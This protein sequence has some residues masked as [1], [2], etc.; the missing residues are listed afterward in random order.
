MPSPALLFDLDGTLVDTAPDL[1]G[2][3]NAVL[4][5]EERQTVDPTTLRHMV[6]HGARAL[7]EQAMAATGERAAPERLPQLVDR[8]IAH[9]RAHIV[10]GSRAFPGVEETL[11]QLRRGGA[12]LAV[13]TNK[14]QVLTEPILE[15]LNL[16]QHF[17]V[18]C[19]AGRYDYNKPDAR[20]VEHVV[21]ELGG[22]GTGAVM[23]GDSVTDVATARAANIPVVLLSYG[24]TPES[25]HTLGGDLVID[26]FSD[27][28]DAVWRLLRHT[29]QNLTV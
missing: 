1:L 6:G 20:V 11:V 8:F 16:A 2:A 7:I 26:D 13:L 28:P 12:R 10:D 24:Y 22:E 15:N 19:G 4:I 18:I 17:A 5:S 9:Y 14:P 23:I 25:V 29:A 3:L 21:R 27:V